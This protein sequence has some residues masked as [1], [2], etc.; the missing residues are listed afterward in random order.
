MSVQSLTITVGVTTQPCGGTQVRRP[1]PSG[2]G[3]LPFRTGVAPDGWDLKDNMAEQQSQKCPV[4]HAQLAA[5][6]TW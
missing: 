4:R 2:A 3:M 6:E 5:V 1:L